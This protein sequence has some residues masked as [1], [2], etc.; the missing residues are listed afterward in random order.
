[1]LAIIEQAGSRLYTARVQPRWDVVGVGASAVD[2]VYR[3]PRAPR[4]EGPDSKLRITSHARLCGG[5]TATAAATCASLGLRAAYAGA[6]GDDDNA[7]L[8]AGE[9]TRRGVDAT[10]AV[11]RHAPH[12]FAVILLPEDSGERIVL[13]DRNERLA[14]GPEEPPADAIASSRAI[15]VD[16]VDEGAAIRVAA[17]AR[18]AGIPATSDI[19]KVTPRTPALVDAVTFA[20]FAEH[21]PHDLTGTSDLER[22]VRMLQ[23]RH[24]ATTMV[25]TL[26]PRGAAMLDGAEFLLEPAFPVS[27]VDTTGAGDVFR[28]AF[29]YGLLAGL[30][31]RERLRVAN[32]AAA[33]ACTRVG[34]INGVPSMEEIRRLLAS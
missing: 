32:A 23:Q 16:D 28:G 25:V 2:Y 14:L 31:P 6:L 24:G 7:R 5:Q 27:V 20:I 30:P 10:P 22:A 3:L 17:T 15:H 1:M 12:P 29:I 18:A 26:G 11:V 33:V 8:L 19:E 4:P 21:V 9:L 13:W 34:A